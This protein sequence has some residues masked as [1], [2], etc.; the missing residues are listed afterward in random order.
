MAIWHS[1]LPFGIVLAI[2]C[3]FW[4]FGIFCGNLVYFVVIWDIFPA[5]ICRPFSMN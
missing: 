3:M 1:L 5:L 4:P 2:W